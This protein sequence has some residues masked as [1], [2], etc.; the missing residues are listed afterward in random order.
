M[1]AAENRE[2]DLLGELADLRL[3]RL[4]SEQTPQCISK[5]ACKKWLAGLPVTNATH[6]QAELLRQLDLLNRY[7]L[8]VAERLEIV[9]SLRAP[10]YFVH[11]ESA[12]RF[13]APPL[14]LSAAEQ[15]AFDASHALWKSLETAYLHCLQGLIEQAASTTLDAA[16]LDRAALAA[17]R[18]LTTA[19]AIQLDHCS[20]GLMPGAH[21]WSRLHRIYLAAER[22]EVST[23]SVTDKLGHTEATTAQAAYAESLLLAAARPH[24][25]RPK[26]VAQV[27]YWAHRWATKTP[28]LR[29]P[30]EDLRT[31]P[32]CVDLTRGQAGEYATPC[33]AATLRWLDMG[34][35]RKTIKQRLVKLGQGASPQ[36]LHL[37]K[38][39]SQPS[40][41]LLLREVYRHWC[42]GG[43]AATTGSGKAYQVAGN[44][45]AIHYHVG[46]R[47][48]RPQEQSVY[49]NKRV[50]ED[51]ATF[52][53]VAARNEEVRPQ[54]A[55]HPLEDWRSVAEGMVDLQLER[56]V[57]AP[58]VRL[59][60][61][62]LVGVR[63]VGD[64]R[65][66]L[67]R[68]SWCCVNPGSGQLLAGLHLL[69]GAPLAV[70]VSHSGAGTGKAQH[71]C[72]FCL[73]A[74]EALKQPESV[75]TPVGW[76]RT[77]LLVEIR[78]ED[79][80][81]TVRLTRL[82]ERGADYDRATYEVL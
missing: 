42:K 27:A 49:L 55:H 30:P 75:I 63:T 15:A 41:E 53:H 54:V 44:S 65:F 35:L 12:K 23:R 47:L 71:S 5:D 58:G 40:C 59:T 20:A 39:C 16:D 14:P 62:Q 29:M 18:A 34:D 72:G 45:E 6:T 9:E 79:D 13:L 74:I 82:V 78:T 10:C 17:T 64:A 50:H 51:I 11:G 19:L 21:H 24:E 36:E 81:R 69:A 28:V 31:P 46:G 1:S 25:L 26:Q 7:A 38:N 70:T 52:G 2:P 60:R 66:Q 43:R 61:D 67:G 3:P 57:A 37:G 77:G 33:A 48:F 4:T 76:Y 56:P 32:L 68:V 8:P 80:V 22:L 73:P